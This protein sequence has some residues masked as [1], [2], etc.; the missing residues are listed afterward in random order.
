VVSFFAAV[1]VG[2][3]VKDLMAVGAMVAVIMWLSANLGELLVLLFMRRRAR[4]RIETATT[5]ED[6]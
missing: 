3:A 6:L 4:F 2:V 5:P 1:I